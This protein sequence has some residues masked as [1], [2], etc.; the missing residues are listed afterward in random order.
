MERDGEDVTTKHSSKGPWGGLVNKETRPW[1]TWR[2]DRW[3]FSAIL[4][5][6]LHLGQEGGEGESA[7]PEQW[8]RTFLPRSPLY[9]SNPPGQTGQLAT[10]CPSPPPFL[11]PRRASI[12]ADETTGME[13]HN[14]RQLPLRCPRNPNL[15]YGQRVDVT[16]RLRDRILV[17]DSGWD[18]MF[19]GFDPLP[20]RKSR[21]G[22]WGSFPS[23]FQLAIRPTCARGLGRIGWLLR[24]WH[25]PP[26]ANNR[27]NTAAWSRTAC[28]IHSESV[29]YSGIHGGRN[30]QQYLEGG[31][32]DQLRHVQSA[33]K[34]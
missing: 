24:P 34:V 23:D 32:C 33:G 26:P 6:R 2:L 19:F 3:V 28:K 1:C 15:F 16:K 22:R 21:R 29:P 11:S 18:G 17:R 27:K 8:F 12:C 9:L 20:Q 13:E 7:S 10:S 30:R 31:V 25:S 4:W 5:T 14:H